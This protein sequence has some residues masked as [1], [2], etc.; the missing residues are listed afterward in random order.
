V[1]QEQASLH[2]PAV[3]TWCYNFAE[4]LIQDRTISRLTVALLG[5]LDACA[6][7]ITP[8]WITMH[9]D[10]QFE[11]D[12]CQGVWCSLPG[13]AAF[14]SMC[15][16][17]ASAFASCAGMFHYRQDAGQCLHVTFPAAW[18]SEFCPW[19]TGAFTLMC[20]AHHHRCKLSVCVCISRAMSCAC[21]MNAYVSH[22]ACFVCF[23]CASAV[24]LL[25]A[26]HGCNAELRR[27][28]FFIS[29]LVCYPVRCAPSCPPAIAL[30][31]CA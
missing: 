15:P 24:V 30:H 7:A 3:G 1:G 12:L 9:N 6:S 28:L 10:H 23:V 14:S 29:T 22:P 26:R 21:R 11:S 2:E 20:Q 17:A 19:R 13:V 25:M 31:L 27:T 5:S 16:K 8:V 4:K 18:N